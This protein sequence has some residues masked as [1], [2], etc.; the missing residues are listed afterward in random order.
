MSNVIRT[1]PFV[2]D[3]L[4]VIMDQHVTKRVIISACMLDVIKAQLYVTAVWLAITGICVTLH[5]R[6]VR[7]VIVLR[8][9]VFVTL[10]V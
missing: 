5:A 8:V 10:A 6:D 4:T 1:Q 2:S 7:M 3:A 9:T